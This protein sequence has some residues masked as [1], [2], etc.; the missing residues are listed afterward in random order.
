MKNN[1]SREEAIVECEVTGTVNGTIGDLV[2]AVEDCLGR[3]V[4]ILDEG[5]SQRVETEGIDG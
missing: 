5:G 3:C 2:S 1:L 4:M